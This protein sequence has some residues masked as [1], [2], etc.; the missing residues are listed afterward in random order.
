MSS[1]SRLRPFDITYQ[2][3]SN[4]SSVYFGM[5]VHGEMI[6]LFLFPIPP[7]GERGLGLASCVSCHL[8]HVLV[9]DPV[10]SVGPGQHGETLRGSHSQLHMS[11]SAK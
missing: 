4:P 8:G 1:V 10:T 3:V 7:R 9:S 5:Y 2:P 6:P 11:H